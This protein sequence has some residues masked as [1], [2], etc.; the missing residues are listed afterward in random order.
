[1]KRTMKSPKKTV[2]SELEKQHSR[3]FRTMETFDMPTLQPQPY[4]AYPS[5]MRV[6]QTVTTYS[7]CEEPIPNPY[8]RS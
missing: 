5:P 4:P 3:V 8:K 7:A 6:V 1:M 2:Q